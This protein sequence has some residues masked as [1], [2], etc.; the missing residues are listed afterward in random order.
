MK[1]STFRFAIAG[2]FVFLLAFGLASCG[3][4]TDP[5]TKQLKE[6]RAEAKDTFDKRDAEVVQIVDAALGIATRNTGKPLGDEAFAFAE[7][8]FLSHDWNDYYADDR[9]VKLGLAPTGLKDKESFQAVRRMVGFM[10]AV[11]A[12]YQPTQ[13]VAKFDEKALSTM[14]T[15][16]RSLDRALETRRVWTS[17]LQSAGSTSHQFNSE[18]SYTWEEYGKEVVYLRLL[19]EQI[20]PPAEFLKGCDLVAAAIAIANYEPPAAS[21]SYKDNIFY[22]TYTLETVQAATAN[23]EALAAAIAAARAVFPSE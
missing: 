7:G 19:A 2:A 17:E 12:P 16:L 20:G 18:T 22:A 9:Y 6:L 5:D 3:G 13:V 21:Q 15:Y 23:A 14:A 8:V 1:T 11:P 4:G 10:G